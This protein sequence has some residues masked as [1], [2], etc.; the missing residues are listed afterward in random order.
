MSLKRGLFYTLITQAPTL[1]LYFAASTLMTRM[2][3]EVGRGE[4]ALITNHSVLLC[5]LVSL[6]IGFGVTYFI[7]KHPNDQVQV[8]RTA[9][10]LLLLN[11]ILV[12]LILLLTARSPGATSVM[13]PD[14]RVQWMYWGYVFTQVILSLL[15]TTI[16]AVLLGFKRFNALNWMSLLNAGLSALGMLVLFVLPDQAVGPD[17]F[18]AVLVVSTITV[19]LVSVAWCVLYAVHVGIVPRPLLAWKTLWPVI[20]FSLVGHLSNLINLIN[21]RFD[22]WVVDRYQGVA[23][24]GLY[25]VA[26]GVAQ[27]LFNIPEPFSRVVQPYLFGQVKDEMLARF[28]SVSRINFTT[29]LVLATGL[30]TVAP[31]LIPALFGEQFS[32]SIPSLWFLLPGIV[33]SGTAKLLAQLVIQGGLQRFNLYGT[34][35]AAIFTIILDLLLIPRWGIQGAAI[36]TSISY[37]IVL[38][39]ILFT[40]RT[41]MGIAVHDL[42]LL[43]PRDLAVLLKHVPRTG[44]S[45]R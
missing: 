6:N 2:L 39:I 17:R 27:L 34:A 31:W 3:G 32:A 37:G 22:V 11:A 16:G 43:R 1:V 20:S 38:V 40:I 29:L 10:T 35:C 13:M 21:Y 12:P 9:A 18:P 7:S 44:S 36:A 41:R 24:L 8:I 14:G 4:Y 19:V 25:A 28:K 15:N 30:A 45:T 5:M 33:L 26:V 23:E 42:F